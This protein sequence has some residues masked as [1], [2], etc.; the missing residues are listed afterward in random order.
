MGKTIDLNALH[1]Y[2]EQLRVELE[3]LFDLNSELQIPQSI[4]NC[5]Q[6]Q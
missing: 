2:D 6:R 5:L 1:G 4:E 3:K